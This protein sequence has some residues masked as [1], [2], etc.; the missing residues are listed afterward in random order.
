MKIDSHIQWQSLLG[1]I[2]ATSLSCAAQAAT[3][4]GTISCPAPAA[5]GGQA[6]TQ[7]LSLEIQGSRAVGKTETPEL[8]QYEEL[9][10]DAD[11][12]V[13]LS[14]S[15]VGRR[16]D[17]RWYLHA[18]GLQEGSK[19]R[20][21]APMTGSDQR[22]PVRNHCIVQFE[23][24][25]PVTPPQPR[26]EAF[27]VEVT[28]SV[29]E[30]SPSTLPGG[31]NFREWNFE[32]GLPWSYR[33]SA[34]ATPRPLPARPASGGEIHPLQEARALMRGSTRVKALVFVDDD[35]VVSAMA[36]PGIGPSTLLPSASMSKSLTALG[37]GKALCAGRLDLQVQAAALLP[38]LERTV[39]GQATL[40]QILLMSSGSAE[41]ETTHT[42][43]ITY[44]EAERFLQAEDASLA[45]LVALPRLTRAKGGGQVFDY[46]STD[47]YLAA[48][49]TQKATGVPFTRWLE[50]QVLHAAGIAH[51][52]ILDTDRQGNFLATG[53]VR[54]VLADWVR[55]SLWLR[56]Q[57]D[58]PGCF[59][60]FVRAMGKTQVRAPKAEGINGF[61]NGYSWFTWTEADL[62]PETAWFVG[63]FG[64]RLAWST[65]PGN[66]R[67]FL[68]F[69]DGSDPEMGRIYPLARRWIH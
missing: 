22:T 61:F 12:A 34:S 51:P 27:G 42:H 54:L 64:Q 13:R 26:A 60:D 7:A 18:T 32:Q 24:A 39:V 11:G 63:H 41:T 66:K 37:V 15:G 62:A 67:L 4:A 69:G 6:Y 16:D 1:L 17:R 68:T 35:Q 29:L 43:G 8:V 30:R 20:M 45:D 31:R 14:I 21:S 2:L 49:M 9:V 44:A 59:G 48:L 55:L 38:A 52:F 40:R 58:Q 56:E 53:G 50:T 57:R 5:G 47:P 3:L 36:R 23:P 65:R 33:G 46:K 19:I 25:S 28:G 10:F